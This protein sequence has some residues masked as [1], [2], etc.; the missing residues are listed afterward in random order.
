M[1][2]EQ[3]TRYIASMIESIPDAFLSV[4][5]QWQITYVNREAEK[6]LQKKREDLLGKNLWNEFPETL[7]SSFQTE[8]F[9]AIK[10]Q[11]PAQF[12]EY[13]STYD[14]WFEVHATPFEDGLCVYFHDI[15]QRKKSNEQLLSLYFVGLQ[16]DVTR[17]KLAEQAL[18]AE[19]S[20]AKRV[21]QSVLSPPIQEKNIE[22]Q[23]VYIPSEQ[24]AGDMYCWY[25][26]D[27]NRYGILLLDVVGHGISASLIGMSIRS[28]LQ[29]LITRLADPVKVI[30]ELNRHMNNLYSGQQTY[31][32]YYFTCLYVVVD[33]KEKR[34]EYVNAGHPPG[35]L[36]TAEGEIKQ[37]SE[38]C[39]PVGLLPKLQVKKGELSYETSARIVL[40]T[41]GF[42][43]NEERAAF[44]E[45]EKLE[46][47]LINNRQKETAD[48]IEG[49][50]RIFAEEPK[51]DDVCFL[52]VTLLNV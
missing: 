41:D 42:L 25:K 50:I 40:Y 52:A 7:A 47:F 49:A 6:I 11:R 17:R 44:Q 23:A 24:L 4:N 22:I 19:L 32:S 45:I 20:L 35:I 14:K 21:Q 2:V 18:Q 48:V 1:N 5:K 28:L 38:G 8:Y 43:E 29:G 33:T 10:E 12:E 9:R 39:L 46:Q 34:I 30:K 27:A 3:S 13:W 16:M 51:K 26:I 15:T 37:L 36:C 31:H